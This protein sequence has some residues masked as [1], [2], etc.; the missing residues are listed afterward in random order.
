MSSPAYPTPPR[1]PAPSRTMTEKASGITYGQFIDAGWS[2]ALLIENGYMEKPTMSI[3]PSVPA[4]SRAFDKILK[5]LLAR[6]EEARAANE[7]AGN[8]RDALRDVRDEYLA[9]C[10]FYKTEAD[11]EI[12]ES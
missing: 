9:A 11:R 12:K 2:E 1:A 8:A 10:S 3:A 4:P 5:D 7:A 6:T